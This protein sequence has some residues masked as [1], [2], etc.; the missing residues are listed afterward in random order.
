MPAKSFPPGFGERRALTRVLVV[1]DH[2]F[3]RG[4][5]VDL[6]EASPDLVAVGECR[7]GSEVAA[8]VRALEPQVVLMDMR[9]RQRN[10]LDAAADL[11]RDRSPAR[12]I[13]LTSDPVARAAAEAH[14]ALGYLLKGADGALVLDAVRHVAS[15]GTAWPED[16]AAGFARS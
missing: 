8:A 2:D 6:I 7:D 12:V 9:M 5:L 14:G 1:D 15:G 3:F 10:G 13:M 16:V 11:R 4:C